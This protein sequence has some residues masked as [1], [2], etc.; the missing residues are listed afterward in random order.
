MNAHVGPTEERIAKAQGNVAVG[1]DRQGT[2]IYHFL[3]TPLLRLYKRLGTADKS[4]EAT[5]QLRR[6]FT[7]L[8]KYRDHWYY[9]GLETKFGS[10]DMDRVQSSGG[11]STGERQAHHAII[12]R[13][14]AKMLGLWNSH[15]V[16]HIACLDRSVVDCHAFGIA[17]SPYLFRKRLRESANRLAD[18]WKLA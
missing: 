9:A 7:A 15:I 4:D 5:D 10:I 18:S 1:D 13:K 11:M 14:A 16:E 3:D 2:K 6:E 8:M 12:Y 17:I